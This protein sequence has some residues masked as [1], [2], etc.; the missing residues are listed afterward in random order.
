MKV[1]QNDIF[2]FWRK[3]PEQPFSILEDV[4]SL[5][6]AQRSEYDIWIPLRHDEADSSIHFL[7]EEGER[8]E[9][10]LLNVTNMKNGYNIGMYAFAICKQHGF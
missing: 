2:G 5:S 3:K 6:I 10:T 8:N 4:T 1:T 9:A 7:I